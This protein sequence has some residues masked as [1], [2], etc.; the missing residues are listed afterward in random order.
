VTQGLKRLEAYWQ[1]VRDPQEVLNIL[2]T[3]QV[4]S[5]QGVRES[6]RL[7]RVQE[8]APK[9]SGVENSCCSHLNHKVDEING[10]LLRIL[11]VPVDPNLGNLCGGCVRVDELCSKSKQNKQ[12]NRHKKLTISNNKKRRAAKSELLYEP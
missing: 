8:S 7:Q 12:N 3:I 5:A 9:S 6:A 4:T 2:I 1:L 10:R 11:V